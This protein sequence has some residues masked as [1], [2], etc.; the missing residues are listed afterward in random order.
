[1]S[2]DECRGAKAHGLEGGQAVPL[3][4]REQCHAERLVH[5]ARKLIHGLVNKGRVIGMD[6]VEITPALDVNRIS[7]ITAGRL[8]VNLIGA[9]IKAGYFER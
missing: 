3:A 1:M 9:A 6:I 2:E 4:T 5:Q 7:S 8:F